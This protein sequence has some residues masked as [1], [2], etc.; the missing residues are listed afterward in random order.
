M[1]PHPSRDAF[2]RAFPIHTHGIRMDSFDG[3]D[4]RLA[5]ERRALSRAMLLAASLCVAV[6][7]TPVAAQPAAPA[8]QANTSSMP[9]NTAAGNSGTAPS[10]AALL[11]QAQATAPRLAESRANV[12][13]AEGRALQAGLLPNPSAGFEVENL[14]VKEQDV[15]Y[16]E[17]QMTLSIAQPIELGGK[18]A[19]RIAA[20]QAGISAAT[21]RDRQVMTDYGYELATVYAAA[22][23]A[24]ARVAL[25]EEAVTAAQEDL[26]A[27]RA[28]VDAGREADLRAVQAEA[29][30]TAA[31]AN[32]EAA[33]A[34]AQ[35]AFAELSTLS[36]AST[37]YTGVVDSLLPLAADLPVPPNEPPVTAPAVVAAQ[38]EREAAARR[39]EVERRRAVPDVTP[40][41][42]V[43]RLTGSDQTVF[44]A[45]VS[46]AIRLFDRNQGNIAAATAELEGFDG[47]LNAARLEALNGW[48]SAVALARA[49]DAR[50]QASAQAQT[51]SDEAYRLARVGYEAGRTPL[52]EVLLAQR[53]LTLA[54]AAAL[55]ARLARIR[56]EAQLARLSAR[57][58]FGAAP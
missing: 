36:G 57:I 27:A 1:K 10:Y 14:G 46:I 32:L 8:I 30:A 42:G 53:S 23:A 41:L 33:R 44:V 17:V 47:R 19:A 18:R 6:V 2:M 55:D 20:G 39:I 26:R 11:L 16:S 25:F 43:R 15:G 4:A 40:S 58:P 7:A 35:S 31:Q 54:S 50:V 21:A 13:A 34:D 24:Q 52:V 45:G 3:P 5:S 22:E 56:A 12:R 37:P 48:R 9:G 51:A 38:A 29:A 49:A 28:L